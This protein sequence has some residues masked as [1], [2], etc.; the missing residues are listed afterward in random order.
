MDL[1]KYKYNKYKNK[2]LD[3]KKELIGG[4]NIVY[5]NNNVNYKNKY[6]KYKNK[7]NNLVFLQNFNAGGIL[8][9]KLEDL[10]AGNPP[11]ITQDVLDELKS[12]NIFQIY[13]KKDV[14][15]NTTR[16]QKFECKLPLSGKRLNAIAIGLTAAFYIG[17]T[18]L[19]LGIAGTVIAGISTLLSSFPIP[20]TI[21]IP[22]AIKNTYYLGYVHDREQCNQESNQ[23][24]D[25][26]NIKNRFFYNYV[27]KGHALND[28]N[29]CFVWSLL[30]YATVT[31]VR[32]S[33]FGGGVVRAVFECSGYV[34]TGLEVENGVLY[35]TIVG[36]IALKDLLQNE[37]N[38]NIIRQ[39]KESSTKANVTISNLSPEAKAEIIRIPV[40]HQDQVQYVSCGDYPS[41]A[42]WH[43]TVKN[44][45]VTNVVI[46][47]DKN[48]KGMVDMPEKGDIIAVAES[49]GLWVNGTSNVPKP[50]D[51]GIIKKIIK[52][53]DYNRLISPKDRLKQPSNAIPNKPAFVEYQESIPLIELDKK[54]L[55]DPHIFPTELAEEPI[56]KMHIPKITDQT[57]YISDTESSSQKKPPMVYRTY[58]NK[59]S[60]SPPTNKTPM[61][62]HTYVNKGSKA[63][64]T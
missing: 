9:N 18:I 5:I 54:I 3:I 63:A 36:N 2:Y 12:Q 51:E 34:V 16:E 47:R 15:I 22:T 50:P 37:I 32:I 56:E 30:S 20:P 21:I 52:N 24:K 38:K 64:V 55:S 10:I 40:H 19:S 41:Q 45:Q 7:Y 46:K 29:G 25:S 1:Y 4:N 39:I 14:N 57:G 8:N 6:K 27:E 13:P 61:V 49:C 31:G 42:K 62:Y 26:G 48:E 58:V 28:Q 59:G 11:T 43:V 44:N 60:M 17:T 53:F 35:F 23:K 33:I